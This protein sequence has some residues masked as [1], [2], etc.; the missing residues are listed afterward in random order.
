MS[1]ASAAQHMAGIEDTSE[2]IISLKFDILQARLQSAW[3]L[4]QQ[5][6]STQLLQVLSNMLSPDSGIAPHICA[7]LSCVLSEQLIEHSMS[8][9]SSF[10]GRQDGASLV[11]LLDEAYRL[12]VLAKDMTTDASIQRSTITLKAKVMHSC[13]SRVPV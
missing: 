12:A 9:I 4:K 10:R 2:D 13:S 8:N 1:L 3:A 7:S 6:L 5:A 11:P